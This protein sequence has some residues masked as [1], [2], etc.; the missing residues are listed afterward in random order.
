MDT[1]EKGRR[2]DPVVNYKQ[3]RKFVVYPALALIGLWVCSL[4]LPDAFIGL[5]INRNRIEK[6]APLL[7]KA[8]DLKLTY[9]QVLADPAGAEGK[10]VTWCV[11]NR[12]EQ[13]VTV[14]GDGNKPLAVSNYARMPLFTGSKHQACT[15]MLLLLEKTAPGRPVSVYFKEAF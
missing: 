15:V 6:I 9:E 13:S 4:W 2:A 7:E 11:Q 3:L 12:G 5:S 10:P 14:D 1:Q 8:K